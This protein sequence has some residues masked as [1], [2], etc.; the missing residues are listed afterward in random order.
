[1][2]LQGNCVYNS[3]S[4]SGEMENFTYTDGEGNEQSGS[5]PAQV[6]VTQSFSDIYVVVDEVY[7]T[8]H[9]QIDESNNVTKIQQCFA[10][11]SG[12]TDKA[13]RNNDKKDTLFNAS[14]LVEN[15]DYNQNA[16]SQSYAE[17]K[18]QP[19]MTNLVDV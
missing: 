2:A 10:D 16:Y 1:M 9:Y 3:Y 11:Y 8:S 18:K 5:R 15:Y 4:A 12:Y 13:T 14:C 6:L 7:L 19:G 17:I